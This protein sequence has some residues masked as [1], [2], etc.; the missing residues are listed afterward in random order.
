MRKSVKRAALKEFYTTSLECEDAHVTNAL[1][2][3][4]DKPTGVTTAEK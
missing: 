2:A 4:E 1:S 3:L